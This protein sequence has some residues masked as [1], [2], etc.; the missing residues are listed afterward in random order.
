[1]LSKYPSLLSGAVEIGKHGKSYV[2]L[3]VRRIKEERG[4]CVVIAV[5][6]GLL[7]HSTL[8]RPGDF[9]PVAFSGLRHGFTLSTTPG[10][11]EG[12]IDNQPFDMELMARRPL[13]N[14]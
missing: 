8:S 11:T 4:G 6:K 14:K 7:T 12:V 5:Q 13:K 9:K 1:M 2:R 3:S 10:I